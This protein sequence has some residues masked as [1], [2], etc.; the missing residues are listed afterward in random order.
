MRIRDALF[1]KLLDIVFP[2]IRLRLLIRNKG[3]EADAVFMPCLYEFIVIESK[4]GSG[5][6]FQTPAGQ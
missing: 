2:C 6:P 5:L 1:I 4:I 3:G